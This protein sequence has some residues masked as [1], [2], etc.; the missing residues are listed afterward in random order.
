MTLSDLSI[1]RPVFAWMLMFG[2]M[3]FGAIAVSR[4]G[5]SRLPD[6]DFAVVN[7]SA[8]WIGA[9]PE[10]MELAVT[11]VIEDSVMSIEGIRSVS[12]TCQEGISNT[13]VEFELSRNIDSAVQEV[14]AKLSQAARRLPNDM[15]PPV[16]TK[17]NPEDQPILWVALVGGAKDASG[18][19][20]KVLYVRDQLKD[21]MT[22]VSGVSDV[23]L[24]GFL[25]PNMR[26]WLD[27]VKM[28]ERQLVVDDVIASLNNGNTLT[29]SG[30][31]NDPK[32]ETSIRVLSDASTVE[33]F[34]NIPISNRGGAPIWTPIRLKDIARIEDGLADVRRI[35][36]VNQKSSI[37]LAIIKQRG[38][39]AVAVGK[40]VKERIR[41]LK[42]QL[43][44][45]MFLKI[46]VDSTRFIEQSTHELL[47]TMAWSALL[48][49]LV[50]WLFLG[51]WSSAFN[52]ILAIPTSLLG[53]FIFLY[54]LGFTLNTFTLLALSLSIGI[55]VDDAIM[56]LENI[57]RYFE[58]GMSRVK[59]ALIGAREIT[60]A[61]VASSVA[62]LAIFIP[63]I[64]MD[65]I[66][67]KFFFQFGVALSVAVM[68]S[69]LE[70]LTLAPMRC[71][72][73]LQHAKKT[74]RI[75]AWV[76][77]VLDQAIVRYRAGLVASLK[78]PKTILLGS[79]LIFIASCFLLTGVQKE[80]IPPSD[81]SRLMIRLQTPMGS[82]IEYTDQ[83][84]K[85]VE[86]QLSTRPEVDGYLVSVGGFQGGLVNQG[87]IFLNLKDPADRP[88]VE[89]FRHRP[90]QQE[91]MP[92]FRKL[93]KSVDGVEQVSVIDLSV[94]GFSSGRGSAIQF[95]IQGPDWQKL[96]EL[97]QTMVS[98]MK[99]SGI[100]TDVDSDFRPNMPEVQI[101]PDRQKAAAQGVTITNI[102]HSINSLVGSLRVGK[103]TD[104]SGHRND[105]R[106]KLE[107][108]AIQNPK[109]IT[110]IW[111]RNN[112]GELIPLSSVV[113]LKEQKTLL[114]ISRFNRERAITL[115]ANLVQG[116][117]QTRAMEF[118]E[119]K[120]K[121]LLPEGY[122]YVKSGNSQAYQ[123]TFRS[124]VIAL[125]L[126]ILVAYMVLGAQFN[127]FIHPITVLLALPF[128][129]TGAFLALRL[130]GVSLNI[131][132]MIGILLLMGIVK[133]NSILLVDFTNVCRENGES[134]SRALLSACPLRLRPILMTSLATIA[135]AIPSA[136]SF[137][138]GAET[139]RPMAVV[140]IGGVL[141]STIFTLFVVPCAYSLFSRFENEAS[142][143][144]LL[145]TV[146]ELEQV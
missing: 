43:P 92:I 85:E 91:L 7:V 17:S 95:Q 46:I 104:S 55:V 53:A 138:P 124:L 56:V 97:S 79:A 68:I 78:R 81:E 109:D 127:S 96:G 28:R 118:L 23:R 77:R 40:G 90:S 102:A 80:F 117:S 120:A 2:L 62:V 105:V 98:D 129:L 57:S 48:T 41:Y 93:I 10:T 103:Y 128:S 18:M 89:P 141:V 121:E 69:L 108:S 135:A 29:P 36:R 83:V 35:T 74:S 8:S 122:H 145:K 64:F 6:V 67:G 114:T 137:G 9:S 22:T 34:M 27:P 60:S 125:L 139:V 51:T 11:D 14:Q 123:D 25:D 58:Q 12:S 4:M 84:F 100:M 130:F 38:S 44:K 15:D 142:K 116:Q 26:I 63:V 113:S 75:H 61:A 5:I 45:N 107:P 37:G 140:V 33:Q 32:T 133:K 119:N 30:Y 146:K 87:N 42:D 76:N 20:E 16:V 73:F 19:R 131:Y 52:V 13:T 112:R 47:V 136:L 21:R 65:G 86:K 99:T 143:I 94:G 111:V 115:Q 132:S 106:V 72:Q 144:E 49:S 82:S 50:C 1:R 71:S 70:A 134:V 39:N 110:R 126:G 54:F 24:G 3:I 88:I 101:V 31:V 66:I 59:A